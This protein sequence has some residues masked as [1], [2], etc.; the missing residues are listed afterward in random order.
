M[1]LKQNPPPRGRGA[2]ILWGVNHF[3]VMELLYFELEPAAFCVQA[4]PAAA[5][6]AA[7]PS[8]YLQFRRLTPLS[9]HGGH[10]LL[11]C[12]RRALSQPM[13][14]RG[15]RTDNTFSPLHDLLERFPDLF[16]QKVLQHLDPIDR[17]FLAQA[18]WACRVAV[19]ASDLPRAGTRWVVLGSSVWV[20]RHRL[21]EFC[22]SVERLAWAKASGCP[23]VAST[24]ALAAR[25]ERLGV[26]KWT[27]AHDCPCDAFTC[28]W[29]AWRGHLEVLRWA[30]EHDCPWDSATCCLCS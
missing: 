12:W 24:C 6:A 1:F 11:R 21:G 26:L 25:G 18:G 29:A 10:L 3:F 30:R 2:W 22:T 23:W 8:V 20:V 17:T 13:G 9:Y 19:A 27:R 14:R 16:A 7:D 4:R 15:D 28:A 5:A